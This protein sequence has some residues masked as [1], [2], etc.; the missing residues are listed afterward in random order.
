[1]N[2]ALANT[3]VEQFPKYEKEDAGKPILNGDVNKQSNLKVC[4]IPGS[5]GDYCLATDACPPADVEKRDFADIHDI[6]Y[7]VNKD[8]PR[9]DA[10]KDPTN[11]PQF[12]NWEKGLKEWLK[13]EGKNSKSNPAPTEDCKKSD[14]LSANKPEVSVSASGSVSGGVTIK[15]DVSAPYEV[16]KVSFSVNGKDA[17]STSSSPYQVSY[18]GLDAGVTSIDVKAMV[19]DKQGNQ[20]SDS[21]TVSVSP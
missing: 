15:A 5:K 10:P 19:T 20:S 9:G 21:K 1:M 17:G 14:F 6:L 11:D 8:D 16:D 2:Q 12:S 18:N 4:K 13:G 7:Y 3:P